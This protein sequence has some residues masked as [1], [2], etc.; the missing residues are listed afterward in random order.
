MAVNKERRRILIC[1]F[2]KKNPDYKKC[3]AVKHFVQMRF[4]RRSVYHI[5][6]K[7][8]DNISLERKLGS[9]R[10]ST[11]SN[12]TERRKLKKATAGHVA[13]S[14]H[15]LGRKFHCDHKTIKH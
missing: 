13:K 12:P 6:K 9:G 14:Y 4:K 8:D 11:L 10:K 7:I 1:D 3:D 5:L 15:E 2:V